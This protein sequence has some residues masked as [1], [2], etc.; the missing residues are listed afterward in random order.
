[1]NYDYLRSILDYN[2]DSGVFRWRVNKGTVKAGTVAGYKR[3]DGYI[4]IMVDGK[5][6]FAH[7]LAWM[8]IHGYILEN[9]IDHI[10][11]DPSNNRINNLREAS[12]Q[13]NLRN[14]GNPVNNTSGIKG[15]YWQK[16][17]GKW[18]ARIKINGK[19]KY[20]GLYD[21]FD[22]AV[23]ARYKA[24]K[25]VNWSGCDSRSPSYRYLKERNLI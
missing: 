16:A 24:E 14:T 12:R 15:I 20:L 23:L 25:A 5:N 17:V 22:K 7:R 9:D 13:C 8:Y 2:P 4:Q 18:H 11:R 19:Y 6:Y 3:P 21:D 10:D 1:M